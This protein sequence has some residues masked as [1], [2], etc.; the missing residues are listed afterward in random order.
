MSML[1]SFILDT[2]DFIEKISKI[3]DLSDNDKIVSF[4]V[5]GLYTNIPYNEGLKAVEHYLSNR[6]GNPPTERI[7]QLL[8]AVLTKN[9]FQFGNKHYI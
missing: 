6:K 2:P 9:N 1:K 4:D 3:D 5:I 8:E 7:L